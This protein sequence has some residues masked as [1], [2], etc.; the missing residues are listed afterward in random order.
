MATRKRTGRPPKADRPLD[1]PAT[2]GLQLP[3]DLKAKLQQRAEAA[4]R[5]LSQEVTMIL[6]DAMA[7][8]S[9]RNQREFGQIAGTWA[10]RIGETLQLLEK[11]AGRPGVLADHYVATELDALTKT[12]DALREGDLTAAADATNWAHAKKEASRE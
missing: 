5:S 6:E 7:G 2:I 11:L 12:I 3:A 10:A 8:P 9:E 1:A 4:R